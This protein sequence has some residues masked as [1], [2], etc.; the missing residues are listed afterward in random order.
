[1]TLDAFLQA[2]LD[3]HAETFAAT[4]EAVLAPFTRLIEACID[5][6]GNGGKLVLFGNGGSAADAQHIATELIVRYE[7]DGV[8]LPAIALTTD[9]SALTA[10]AND[11]SY[12]ELFARQVEALCN[13]G[14]VALGISTSGNSENVIRGLTMAKTRG[15]VAAGFSG[16]DGGRMSGLADPLVVVPARDTGRIQ[17][18][19][20]LLGHMLCGALEREFRKP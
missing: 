19:H 11:Y 8:P 6:Y 3:E 2:E 4:R 12:D 10:I 9:T 17:E 15:A 5:T 16:R 18:M 7:V 13:K 14:D 1:M 20:I